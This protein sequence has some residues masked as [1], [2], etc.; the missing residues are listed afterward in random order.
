LDRGVHLREWHRRF[1]LRRHRGMEMLPTAS[2]TA[3]L[4]MPTNLHHVHTS[5]PTKSKISKFYD[6][7]Y[8]RSHEFWCTTESVC[9]TS[10]SHLLLTQAI[11]ANLNMPVQRQQNII[12]LQIP[13][14]NLILMQ[15]LQCQ[16]NLSRIKSKSA[17]F[18]KDNTEPS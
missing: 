9:S 10:I 5:V 15:I 1:R 3:V 7:K 17:T 12:Q 8:L 14:N 4:R 13:I 18:Q 6:K 16:Q 11:I 2:D